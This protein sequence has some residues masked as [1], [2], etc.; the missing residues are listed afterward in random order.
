MKCE[1]A[2]PAHNARPINFSAPAKGGTSSALLPTVLPFK[3]PVKATKSHRSSAPNT[4]PPAAPTLTNP[5]TVAPV[6][7]PA[8]RATTRSSRRCRLC[9]APRCRAWW[10]RWARESSVS[11]QATR[12]GV[13]DTQHSNRWARTRRIVVMK[14]IYAHFYLC[15]LST[16]L[17]L[18]AKCVVPAL[19]DA[20]HLAAP[21]RCHRPGVRHLHGRRV[22]GGDCSAGDGSVG[23]TRCARGTYVPQPGLVLRVRARQAVELAQRL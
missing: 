23:S 18:L 21:T 7:C 3:Q 6:C 16:L 8:L 17:R 14:I 9:L 15:S 1:L 11:R 5:T 4:Q 2:L 20:T 10:R 22:C 19:A 13:Q 12:C